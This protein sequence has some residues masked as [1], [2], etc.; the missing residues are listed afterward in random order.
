[1]SGLQ[2]QLGLAR[3]LVIYHGQFWKKRALTRF[4]RSI[5]AKGDLCFDIG[6]HVGNRSSA[7]LAAGASVVALE[8]QPAFHAFL[9][10]FFRSDRFTLL[11]QAVAS[12]PGTMTLRISSRHPTVTTLSSDWIGQVRNTDGFSGVLWDEEAQVDVTTL[13][14]LIARFGRPRFC[15]IDVEGMEAEILHGLSEPLDMVAFE[16]LPA[17]LE[18]ARACVLRLEQLGRY[19]FNWTEGEEHRYC[20]DEWLGGQALLDAVAASAQASGRSG[21]IY[22]RLDRG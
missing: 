4:Y 18:I 20:S 13:D 14:S 2:T 19:R 8:P 16:Y 5:C 9:R 12:K 17:S 10:R 22:A 1:M 6:A 21:D 11:K 15:K 7:L 3:S